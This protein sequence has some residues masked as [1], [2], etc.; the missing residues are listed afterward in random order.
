MSALQPR[1]H[2]IRSPDGGRERLAETVAALREPSRYPGSVARVD[3]IET[4]M[5]WVFLTEDRAYKLKKPLLTDLIDHSTIAARRRACATELALNRRLAASVYLALTPVVRSDDQ[6]RVG[7]SGEIVDWLVEMRR[8]AD[9]QMLDVRIRKGAVIAQEI[10]S[11]G[12]TLAEFFIGAARVELAGPDYRARIAA[13]LAAK[14][15]S[16]A[17]PHYGLKTAEI[18]AVYAAQQD[19]LARHADLLERRAARVVDGHGDLRP[20]HVCLER[21]PVVIDCLE[22]AQELRWLDPASELGFLALECRRLGAA[23][24]GARLFERYAAR[25]GDRPP[26]A[27]I[28]FYQ[29]HH[30]LIRAAISVWHLDDHALDHSQRW[31]LRAREYLT[32]ARALL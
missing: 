16:L 15:S 32:L 14:R 20:E 29:R 27:L 12:D 11:L 18:D 26:A 1:P 3:A 28:G 24:I 22:F 8:L 13:D 23:W 9:R 30:A 21:P 7:G 17:Q 25:S 5:S 10:D 19:W 4:H 2:R 6:L 31:R